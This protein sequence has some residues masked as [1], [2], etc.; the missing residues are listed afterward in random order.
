LTLKA[1]IRPATAP[2]PATG[3]AQLAAALP[4][5]AAAFSAL[6][7]PPAPASPPALSEKH[8]GIALGLPCRSLKLRP[9]FEAT[10]FRKA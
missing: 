2:A 8:R 7:S 6:A 3:L 5:N 4:A 1:A 10:D 9:L